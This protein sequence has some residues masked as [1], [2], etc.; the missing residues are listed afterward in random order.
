MGAG[1][2]TA[3][4]NLSLLVVD[5]DDSLRCD[6]AD[7]FTRQGHRVAQCADGEQALELAE[8]QSFDVVVLDLV[9]PGRSGLEVLSQLKERNAECEVVVLSGE[10]TVERA[11]EAM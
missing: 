8:Q 7:F 5:D 4:S 11:V 10:A 2:M 3:K 6:M 1:V 9:M